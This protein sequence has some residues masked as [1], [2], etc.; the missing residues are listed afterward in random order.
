MIPMKSR[1]STFNDGFLRICEPVNSVSDFGA[2]RNTT[3]EAGLNKLG[4]LA[5]KEMSKRDQD[6]DFAESHGRTLSL[7]VKCR[8]KA[9]VTKMHLVLI[10]KTLYS[11]IHMDEGRTHQEMYLYLEEVRKLP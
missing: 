1:F 6:M 2:V 11:I 3:D 7:K 9:E 4:K 5:F 8:L 10:E